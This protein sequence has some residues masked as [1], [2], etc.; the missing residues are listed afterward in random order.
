MRTHGAGKRYKAQPNNARLS[1]ISFILRFFMPR[2]APDAHVLL[3]GPLFRRSVCR[4]A[5]RR[6]VLGSPRPEYKLRLTGALS[7]RRL[8]KEAFRPLT[9]SLPCRSKKQSG[10]F[11]R[12]LIRCCSA[13]CPKLF[14]HRVGDRQIAPSR[15]DGN[16]RLS[17]AVIVAAACCRKSEPAGQSQDEFLI[18]RGVF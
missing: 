16:I 9:N 2:P 13:P 14:Q 4:L 10:R 7:A 11:V 17:A 6:A 18:R 5:P 15:A 12:P 8:G 1:L 3:A